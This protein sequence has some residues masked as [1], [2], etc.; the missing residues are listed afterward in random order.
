MK[1]ISREELEKICNENEYH[2]A[3]STQVRTRAV[4][5][6]NSPVGKAYHEDKRFSHWNWSAAEIRS[7]IF[8]F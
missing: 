7:V 3:M 5:P 8:S 2:G 4:R 6:T 1:A